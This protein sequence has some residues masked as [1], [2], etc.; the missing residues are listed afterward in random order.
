ML[1]TL[2]CTR[3]NWKSFPTHITHSLSNAVVE[4]DED[5]FPTMRSDGDFLHNSNSSKEKCKCVPTFSLKIRM[6]GM[7]ISLIQDG[8]LCSFL[9]RKE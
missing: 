2:L 7:M 9:S 6:N 8:Y 4:D 5:D 1:L 3:K